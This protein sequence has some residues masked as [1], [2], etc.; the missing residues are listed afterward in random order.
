MPGRIAS[1]FALGCFLALSPIL[2][3]AGQIATNA[4]ITVAAAADLTDALKDIAAGFERKTGSHVRLV[5]GSSGNLAAQIWSGAPFDV[6]LS[7][8][9]DY[10]RALAKDGLADATTLRA[11]AVGALAVL[12]ASNSGIALDTRGM[13]ALLDPSVR[14]VAI[15]NPAHAPYGRAAERLLRNLH[16]YDRL[17]PKLVIGENVAQTAQFV[18]SGNAQVGIVSRS[19]GL[20]AARRGAFRMWEPPSDYPPITQGAVVLS[21]S[22][23]RDAARSFLE[24]LSSPEASR[25]LAQYGFSGAAPGQS[26]RPSKQQP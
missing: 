1:T 11:Y 5:F 23:N 14:H 19:Q 15:A 21:H 12:V 7:A 18:I 9:M 24:Y 22:R 3:G 6:F 17:A 13:N 25:I 8:D 10:P 20:V 2:V 4:E 26:E 16:L